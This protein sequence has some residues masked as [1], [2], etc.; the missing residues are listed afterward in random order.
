MDVRR[1]HHDPRPG[2]AAL[3]DQPDLVF[4][5]GDC[6][7]CHG[8]VRRLALAD[9][10]GTRFRFA[11]L[12]GVTAAQRL[13]GA[14]PLPDSIVVLTGTG[15]LLTR[16]RAVRRIA[17]RLAEGGALH[18]RALSALARAVPLPLGDLVYA[19]VARVRRRLAKR[20]EGA[21]PMLPPDLARRFAP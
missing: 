3:N 12:A 6:G 10:D 1:G 14:T 2:R 9:R 20:P 7:F 4:Y 5:D 19:A 18:R 16:H 13:T 17:R 11:P 21:C 8:W 15:E